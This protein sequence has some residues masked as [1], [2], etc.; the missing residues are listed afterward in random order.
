MYSGKH[1]HHPQSDRLLKV[2]KYGKKLT[3]TKLNHITLSPIQG[4]QIPEAL[5]G[6]GQLRLFHNFF[7]PL[8]LNVYKK[9]YDFSFTAFT[10]PFHLY[11]SL[12]AIFL[13][14]ELCDR[15][16]RGVF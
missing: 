14:V 16:R 7:I 5:R 9:V 15:N 2:I 12:T 8:K 6:E 3:I 10:P 13:M 4:V 11:K 1:E